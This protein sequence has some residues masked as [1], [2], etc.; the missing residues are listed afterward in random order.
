[1]MVTK[2]DLRLS[3]KTHNVIAAKAQNIIVRSDQ[4]A[5][6]PEQAQLISTYQERAAPI[7]NR[8]VGKITEPLLARANAAGESLM[9]D[10]IA[11]GELAA[12]KDVANGGAVLA[13]LNSGGIRS[14]IALRPDGTVTYA[15]LF[16]VQP[17]NN[18][19]VTITLTGAQIKT[20]LD[21]QWTDP[22]LTSMLQVSQGFTY[23]WDAARPFGNHVIAGSLMLNGAPIQPQANYRVA[24][25]DFLAGGADAFVAFR[26]GKDRQ[27]AM[28]DIDATEAYFRAHVPLPVPPLDRIQ[29]LN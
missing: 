11:D 27:S 8:I 19:L 17:F 13:F 26:D 24:L 7:A 22:A 23:T 16:A 21:A 10:I 12:T 28:P 3:T 4:L 18:N 20:V 14:N 9:G 29:R 2:I 1:M 6:D 5:S 15:D 25:T